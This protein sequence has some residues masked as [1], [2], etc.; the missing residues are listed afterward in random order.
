MFNH[1]KPFAISSQDL[2]DTKTIQESEATKTIEKVVV[3]TSNLADFVGGPIFR[4]E[5]FYNQTLVRVVMGFAW[6]ATGGSILYVETNAI[7][8][9]EGKGDLIL[10]GQLEDVMKESAQIA[11]AVARSVLLKIDPDN[12]SIRSLF[13]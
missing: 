8:E 11:Q 2:A 13:F 12:H 1:C 9:V 4:P 10:T 3:D 6:T 7:E 5:R